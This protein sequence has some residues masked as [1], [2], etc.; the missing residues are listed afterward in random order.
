MAWPCPALDVPVVRITVLWPWIAEA[1]LTYFTVR[2]LFDS[3]E[4]TPGV[5]GMRKLLSD[6]RHHVETTKVTLPC[7]SICNVRSLLE[8]A[9]VVSD[10]KP[11]AGVYVVPLKSKV[12][13]QPTVFRPS[14]F[15]ASPILAGNV[16]LPYC[17]TASAFPVGPMVT[18]GGSS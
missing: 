8:S 10:A 1:R 12:A 17:H 16:A 5:R 6:S 13:F 18:A 7:A 9:T 3:D 11:D 14:A 15:K 2:M 4:R